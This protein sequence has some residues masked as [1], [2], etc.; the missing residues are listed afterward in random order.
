M[1]R[2]LA[3]FTAAA[4]FIS[5]SVFAPIWGQESKKTGAGSG[6]TGKSGKS[7]K[8]STTESA[9]AAVTKPSGTVEV[10]KC[11]IKLIDDVALA[12]E[13]TGVIKAITVKEGSLIK[14]GEVLIELKDEIARAAHDRAKAEAAND[15]EVRYAE[16]AY[17]FSLAELAVA[18]DTN[19]KVQGTVP[20]IEVKKLRLGASRAKLQIENAEKQLEINKYKMNESAAVVDS[21][22]VRAPFSGRVNKVHKHVGEAVREGELNPI[23]DLVDTSK[24]YVEGN[25]PLRDVL[26]IQIGANVRVNLDIQDADLP[27]EKEIFEGKVVFI[28]AKVVLDRVR[29]RAE[30]SNRGEI[31][32]AGANATM[33][34]EPSRKVA[35]ET[36]EKSGT[37]ETK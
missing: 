16:E 22:I 27:Q 13:R 3:G 6:S 14:A 12:S 30:V 26:S 7:E 24:V 15:I 25:V 2:I 35:A 11:S 33:I 8:S 5:L 29:V 20:E 37:K 19:S 21:Y 34:I 4:L 28:D 1:S 9:P 32:K 31:L 23:V 36:A 17:K 10:F 18:L